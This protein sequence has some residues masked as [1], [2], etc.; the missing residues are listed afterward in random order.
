MRKAE[1]THKIMSSIRSKDTIPEK[2]LGSAMWKHGLRYRKH[3]DIYGKPDFVFIR[4]K[5]AVFCD[6]DFW[7]GNNWRIRGLKNLDE[8]LNGYNDFWKN[9]ILKNISRDKSVNKQL[10]INGWCVMRFWE[11]AI[12]KDPIRIAQKIDKML[13]K[14]YNDTY[15]PYK[16]TTPGNVDILVL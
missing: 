14:R 8:E 2:T 6:G 4:K 11:S 7:H 1:I 10:K 13:N 15:A 5:I 12:R 3:Y 16:T 9:K